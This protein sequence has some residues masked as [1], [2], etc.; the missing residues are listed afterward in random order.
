MND[1]MAQ[2]V[3]FIKEIEKAKT[4]VRHN[5]TLDGRFENDAEHQWQAALMAA[6]FA[7][8]FPAELDMARVMQMLLIH[9][10]GEIGAGDT[11]AYD[12]AGKQSSHERER[13]SVERT[14][15]LLP[16]QQRQDLLKNWL[17]FEKGDSAEAHYARAIDA[18]VPLINHLAV[19]EQNYN[20]ENLTAAAVLKKKAFIQ[21]ESVELWGL[22]EQLVQD[23]VEKRL[24][25]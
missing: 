24:Y 8:Y 1:K 5:R 23:S 12:E 13:Q 3:Q 6:I 18:L 25:L 16:D 14:F 17:E 10:L 20:P 4:V 2:Q 22:V 15:G 7:E 21:Q 9:D 19:A 11:W